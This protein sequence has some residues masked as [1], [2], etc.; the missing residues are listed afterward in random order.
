MQGTPREA[1]TPMLFLQMRMSRAFLMALTGKPD[2]QLYGEM[3]KR[4]RTTGQRKA[5]GG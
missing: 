1:P 3:L 5:V 4:S 2:M